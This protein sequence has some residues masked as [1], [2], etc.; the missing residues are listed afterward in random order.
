MATFFLN[1]YGAIGDASAIA[2]DMVGTIISI[3]DPPKKQNVGLNILLTALSTG[4]AFI[5]GPEAYLGKALV[6]GAQQ[7]PGVAKFL[8]PEGTINS[9]TVEMQE[10]SANLGWTTK[11]LQNNVAQALPAILNDADTF[12]TFAAAGS[13]S[14]NLP[15]ARTLSNDILNGLNAYLIS[16]AYQENGVFITRQLNTSVRALMTNGTNLSYNLSC[17]TDYDSNGICDTFWYDSVDDTTY[18]LVGKDELAR[19]KSYNSD[20]T[21]WFNQYTRPELLFRGAANCAA[22]SKANQ[23]TGSP[24][25]ISSSDFNTDCLSNMKVCTWSL[26]PVNGSLGPM[27][28]E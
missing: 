4:L 16:Q 7:A 11:T 8:F 23:G 3:T 1:Y 15:S 26:T 17:T 24:L 27:F 6:I 20:M 10:V 22:A 12:A 19:T 5:P 25:S 9:Q 18:A 2:S 13:F 21:T 14:A 28:S